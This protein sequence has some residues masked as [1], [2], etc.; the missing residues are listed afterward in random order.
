V[1]AAVPQHAVVGKGAVGRASER[2]RDRLGPGSIAVGR[3]LEDRAFA[4]ASLAR[5]PVHVAGGVED[6]AADGARAVGAP[7]EAVEHPLLPWAAGRRA[8]LVHTPNFVR[9]VVVARAEEIAFRV[10]RQCPVWE[11]DIGF[12]LELV[13]GL[14]PPLASWRLSEPV[15]DPG[16]VLPARGRDPVERA[17]RIKRQATFRAGRAVS[18]PGEGVDDPERP[19]STFRRGFVDHPEPER[20]AGGGRPEDVSASVDRHAAAGTGA[21]SPTREGVDHVLR[22]E[23]ARL[24]ELVQDPAAPLAPAAGP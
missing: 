24:R 16:A 18:S 14:Q 5:R 11:P 3:E 20:A 8:E 4:G 7:R 9:A 10:E 17:A 13:E 21:V 22:P 12:A 2:V 23:P 19:A 15:G 1:P 6:E